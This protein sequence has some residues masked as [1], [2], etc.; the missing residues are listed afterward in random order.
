M[1]HCAAS[2]C[3]LQA[4]ASICKQC[5]YLS[6]SGKKRILSGHG[7]RIHEMSHI[8]TWFHNLCTSFGTPARQPTSQSISK[9]IETII[10]YIQARYTT[11]LWYHYQ[12]VESS[13][14]RNYMIAIGNIYSGTDSSDS[15]C[16]DHA[17]IYIYVFVNFTCT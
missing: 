6:C 7:M 10:Q 15:S 5:C 3:I 4:T 14:D 17:Y 1:L 9:Q 8:F 13:A 12:K 11:A 16:Y 2:Y